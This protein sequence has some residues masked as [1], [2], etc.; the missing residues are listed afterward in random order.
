VNGREEAG[1]VANRLL[2]AQEK[3]GEVSAP[4]TPGFLDLHIWHR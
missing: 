2:S 3:L 4:M 1:R